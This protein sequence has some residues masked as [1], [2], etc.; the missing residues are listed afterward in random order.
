VGQCQGKTKKGERCRRDA[1]DDAGF[2][3]IHQ[4]QEVRG[5]TPREGD[6]WDRDAIMKAAVGFALVG[7]FLLFRFRR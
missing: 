3:S 6:E 4:D 2:C 1:K 7:A 5:R